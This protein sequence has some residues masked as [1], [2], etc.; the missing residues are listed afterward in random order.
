MLGRVAWEPSAYAVSCG[1]HNEY[2]VVEGYG[3]E[4]GWA[5]GVFILPVH[6]PS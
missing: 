1:L 2:M 6:V 5:R 4:K 3:E